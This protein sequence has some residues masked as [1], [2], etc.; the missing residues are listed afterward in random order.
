MI[1]DSHPPVGSL[2]GSDE[3]TKGAGEPG[4][5]NAER[6]TC[7]RFMCGSNQV[8]SG[9]PKKARNGGGIVRHWR[10][11]AKTGGETDSPRRTQRA[12]ME[13]AM[14]GA[15]RQGGQR[16]GNG[17]ERGCDWRPDVT[18]RPTLLVGQNYGKKGVKSA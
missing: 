9:E 12:Q 10:D 3:A 13:R 4:T 16:G 7:G 11:W 15:A 14:G 2:R 18:R 8:L 5:G 6:G 1:M 17:S